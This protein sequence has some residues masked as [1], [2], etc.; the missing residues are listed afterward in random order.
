MD[1]DTVFFTHPLNSWR[2]I[3]DYRKKEWLFRGQRV[4]TWPLKSSLER[5]CERSLGGL[6]EACKTETKLLR[7]F[8]RRYHQYRAYVP[9][10]GDV[11]EWFSIMQHF[12][13]PTRLRTC[14]RRIAM[15]GTIF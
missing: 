13:A 12:G 3:H 15:S 9:R 11:L 10:E 4:A 14:F 8:G 1:T 7:E 5:T 2:E 6:G